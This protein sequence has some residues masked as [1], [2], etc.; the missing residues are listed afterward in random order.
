[1]RVLVTGNLGYIGA[2]AVPLLQ[3]AGHTVTGC[4]LG[5]FEG[6]NWESLTPPNDQLTKDLR[7]LTCD[8]VA[9]HD[10]IVHLAAI[11]NDPMGE[12]D[13][14][15][16]TGVN[17]NGTLHLAKLAKEAGV[18][19]FLFAGSCSIYGKSDEEAL[20]ESSQMAPLSA[21]AVSKVESERLLRTLADDNFSPTY[22]RNATAFGHSPMLRIDLVA[23]NL[24]GCALARNRI[25]IHSDGTPWR[26]L[27]HCKDIARAFV[28]CLEAPRERLHN[29]AI[30][31]GSN[32]QNYQVRDV[33]QEVKRL[34]PSSTVKYTGEVGSDPRDYC[35]NF[36]RLGELLPDFKVEYN[37]ASGLEELH[38][39]M[40]E[41]N[42]SEADFT[43]D[44]FVR[45]RTLRH[46]L[47]AAV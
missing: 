44:Q 39:K 23:N 22:L 2:W 20:T 47:G 19:R 1:M 9:G 24:L 35:V 33:A 25:E 26:P 27:V 40:L 17:L 18:D 5:L 7:E 36:D 14:E 15:L 10:A 21:Y 12:M 6:C 3:E 34:V 31:I 46:R 37:L 8:D 41:H 29:V 4:D 45:L 13:P 11:S 32:E 28:A 30:N 42:F 38:E 43:G 16:T